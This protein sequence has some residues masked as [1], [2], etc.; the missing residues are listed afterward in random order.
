MPTARLAT[1]G[2]TVFRGAMIRMLDHTADLGSECGYPAAGW[3]TV[4][5]EIPQAYRD[6]AAVI[7]A[8]QGAGTG[9]KVTR[10]RPPIVVKG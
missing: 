4:N 10:L 3:A 1:G 9:R 2:E 6:V 5:E 7:E 8:R